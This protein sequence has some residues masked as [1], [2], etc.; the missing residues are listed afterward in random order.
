MIEQYPCVRCSKAGFTGKL[1][2]M[3]IELKL[4]IAAADVAILRDLPLLVRYTAVAPFTETLLSTYFDTPALYLKQHRSA[5]RVRKTASAWIQTFKGGGQV[6]G[7]LHQR[8]EW[9]SEVPGP[10]LDL[11]SLL[12]LIDLPAA[13]AILAHPG[14]AQQL[15]PVF[16]TDFVRTVWMLQLAQDTVVELALDQGQVSAGQASEPI[17]EIELELKAGQLQVLLDFSETLKQQLPLHPSNVS[18]AQRGFSL[19][20]P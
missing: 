17:S 13:R 19:A 18:K 5:L 6:E 1:P 2:G 10:A 15:Q 12:P 8:Y 14:L 9:E 11:D 7:G 4:T 16:T 3:E 20:F